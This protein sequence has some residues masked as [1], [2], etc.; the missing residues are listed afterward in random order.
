MGLYL[1]LNMNKIYKS[2]K[3]K[4]LIS[5]LLLIFIISVSL[6]FFSYFFITDYLKAEEREKLETIASEKADSDRMYF[7]RKKDLPYS[8]L[9]LVPNK[10]RNATLIITLVVLIAGMMMSLILSGSISN[11]LQKLTTA[12]R[13]MKKERH[14]RQ[15]QI[16]SDDEVGALASAFNEMT[17][18]LNQYQDQLE[19]AYRELRETQAMLIQSEK[20][21]ALGEIGV[22]IAHELNSPLAGVLSLLRSHM[23]DK[24]TGSEEYA[25][26]K[27]MEEACE[28]MAKIISDFGKF[29]KKS[30]EEC[31]EINLV[32]IVESTL[33]LAGRQ[34]KK[35]G[36]KVE[37]SFARNLPSI[38]GDGTQLRQVALNMIVNSLDA[39]S[40]KGVLRISVGLSHS[41]RG[42]FV[43]MMFAD[44]G[45][46]I[47]E[48]NI[49]KIY[50]PFFTTKR[51]GK[52]IGLGLSITHTI[53]RNHNGEILVA[54]E[55]G[56]GTV[57]TIRLPVA[58]Q[59]RLNLAAN[60]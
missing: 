47:S 36:I 50:N 56:K 43:E 22:G 4:I 45:C 11:P 40:G 12:I 8:E 39:M 27:L 34:L 32:D 44:N 25:E 37:K 6:G 57:F 38:L 60:A 2:I 9:D 26:L 46:G 30:S 53:I 18:D 31:T 33:S 23:K 55:E 15:V 19:K 10:M 54:S 52:G 41:D 14:L 48:K 1:F 29:T 21:T 7:S 59:R 17:R 28:H 35:R 24:D 51:P 58:K 16:E 20:L 13:S 5:H 49:S 42:E 3:T